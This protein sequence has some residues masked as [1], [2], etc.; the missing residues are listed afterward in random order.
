MCVERIYFSVENIE[1]RQIFVGVENRQ[2]MPKNIFWV[3]NG[4]VVLKHIFFGG[5]FT[6][7][8]QKIFWVEN[9][10]FLSKIYF[11]VEN[12]LFIQA[13]FGTTESDNLCKKISEIFYVSKIVYIYF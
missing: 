8:V 5:K 9:R 12:P 4:Q 3:E 10:Q 7:C 13:T 6:I 11:E 2:L 1:F